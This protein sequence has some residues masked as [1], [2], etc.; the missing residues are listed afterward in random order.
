MKLLFCEF[1]GDGFFL[2]RGPIRSC[3]CGRVKGHY[4][5][6]LYAEVTQCGV[7]IAIG[8]GSLLKAIHEMRTSNLTADERDRK[9]ACDMVGHIRYA[10]VRP[11]TGSANPHTRL[12][13]DISC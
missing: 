8:N 4:I 7:S 1:C 6:D 5:D 10:W 9:E 11:N 2:R 12:I 13:E 3:E